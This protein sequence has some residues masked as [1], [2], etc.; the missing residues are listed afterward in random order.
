MAHIVDSL[1]GQALAHFLQS[2]IDLVEET[3]QGFDGRG[4]VAVCLRIDQPVFDEIFVILV[5][6]TGKG[7][8]R[9]ST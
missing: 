4:H 2:F 1:P 6:Y 5:E 3:H 7:P 9:S 8:K